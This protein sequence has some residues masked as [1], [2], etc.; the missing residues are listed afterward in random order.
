MDAAKRA[1]FKRRFD[2]LDTNGDG[3]LDFIELCRLLKRGNP[4]M[5]D[6]DISKLFKVVDGDGSG[7]VDFEEFINYLYQP[8]DQAEGDWAAVQDRF[9]AF[10]GK[11]GL[12]GK[13]FMKFA[14]DS[15]L[16]DRKFKKTDIDIVFAKVVTKGTR[17][18]NWGQFQSGIRLIAEKKECTVQVVQEAIEATSGPKLSGTKAEAN[19][20]HDDKASYT[21]SHTFNEKHGTDGAAHAV[22]G[23]ARHERLAASAQVQE[24]SDEIDWGAVQ[25]VYIAFAGTNGLDNAEFEKVCE[26]CG[27][28]DKSFAVVDCDLIFSS[29][30]G[31]TARKIEYEEFKNTVRKIAKRK[32]CET[33]EI[34]KQICKTGGPIHKGTEA[35]FNRFHDDKTSY[36]G[37]HSGK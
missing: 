32:G 31:R 5:R 3:Q 6:A 27:L 23:S 8:K 9:D 28:F 19:R 33:Q 7:T 24:G 21:G 13:E 36:T 15:N 14:Q 11:D 35:G 16:F 20:F 2:K 30:K 10:G 1:E 26:D 29:V 25:D 17:K 37:T 34:Q 12:D 22:S 4:N 18:I